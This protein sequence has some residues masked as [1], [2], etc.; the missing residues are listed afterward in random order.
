MKVLPYKWEERNPTRAHSYIVNPI[1]DFLPKVKNL[2]IID[3]GCGNGYLAGLL[4]NLGHKVIAL[5]SSGDGIKIAKEAYPLVDFHCL[6]LYEDIE[7]T[8]GASFD[9]VIASEVIEHLY[10]PRT[11]LRIAYNILK[12]GGKLLLSTPYHGYLKNIALAVSGKMDRHFCVEMDC[13]H[14]KFFS[15]KTLSKMVTEEG[16]KELSFK[17][18][19]RLPF[20]WKSM[21]LNAKK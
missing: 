2:R 13:G 1:L 19:G 15:V 11:F 6:S 16:F 4:A 9:V 10:D 7:K 3:L 21:I 5:D 8:V 18:A 14:I 20:L 12:P 17:F